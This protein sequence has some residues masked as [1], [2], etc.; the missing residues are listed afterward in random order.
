MS[1]I[2]Q[3]AKS[4]ESFASDMKRDWDYR[5]KENAKWFINT[6]KLHQSDEEFYATGM[7]DIERFVLN[8]PILSEGRDLKSLRILE[9]GCGIGRMTKHLAQIYGEV[10]GVD[11][12]AEMIDLARARFRG[13]NNV[14]FYESNGLDFSALPDDYFNIIFSAY[15][16]QHA[17]SVDVIHAN[18]RDACR[19]LKPGGVFKFQTSGI[20]TPAFEAI[21]KDTWTGTSFA[22]VE[23]RRAAR[24]NGA[25]LVSITGLGAQY[26]W[27]ILR[28]PQTTAP[29]APP[30]AT[31]PVIEFFGRSDAPET[32]AIPIHGALKLIVSGFDSDIVDANNVV[33]EIK[34]REFLPHAVN[35]VGVLET[36]IAHIDVPPRLTR[37]EISIPGSVQSGI[38]S[39]RV[40]YIEGQPSEAVTIELLEPLRIAPRIELIT[41]IV[42]GAVDVYTQGEKS[43]FRVFAHGLDD[44]ATPDNVRVLVDEHVIKPISVSFLPS[45]CVHMAVAQM[46]EN[47]SAGESEVR[48]QFHDLISENVQITIR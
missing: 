5:A 19:T 12:S 11:V 40:K 35:R 33:V 6:F 27:T 21:P 46:P 7:V 18:I 20:T 48:I 36:D 41:N 22:E 13:S 47:I 28:K 1:D 34:G 23:I 43:V 37:I 9:I 14:F 24:E 10:H 25:Q 31:R 26:C 45:N 8:D 42:D 30:P 39:V 17:P 29:N 38:A 16:F 15:V 44:S 32:K 4:L 2:D 3:K